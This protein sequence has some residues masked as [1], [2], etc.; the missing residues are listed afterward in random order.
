MIVTL[1]ALTRAMQERLHLDPE[2]AEERAELVLDLFG[3]DD[4]ILDNLLE[5]QDRQLFY[6]LERQGLITAKSEENQLWQG[7]DWRTHSWQMRPER[8][9]AA[10][11]R[12]A[13]SAPAFD[14]TSSVY[15]ALPAT[16]WSR[17]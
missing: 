15:A 5:P 7:Q 14:E 16:C 11:T 17:R 6:A 4:E 8:V 9:H 2:E 3:F 10:A 13:T 12:P 1:E